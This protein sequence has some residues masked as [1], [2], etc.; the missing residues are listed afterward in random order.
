MIVFEWLWSCV[1][2]VWN[3]FMEDLHLTEGEKFLKYWWVYPAV[4]LGYVAFITLGTIG[5]G[6]KKR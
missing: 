4:L 6:K 1:M 2:F 3:N 5:N